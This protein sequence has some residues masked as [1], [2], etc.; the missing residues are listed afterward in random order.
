MAI[1]WKRFVNAGTLPLAICV[2]FE[3]SYEPERTY[4]AGSRSGASLAE[5]NVRHCTT[6]R[7]TRGVTVEPVVSLSKLRYFVGWLSM[8][9]ATPSEPGVLLDVATIGS[10]G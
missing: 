10:P 5:V 4:E 9:L 7:P 1:F 6:L 8:A 2:K 3:P